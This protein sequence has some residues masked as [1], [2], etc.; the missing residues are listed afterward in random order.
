M[1]RIAI[2][3]GLLLLAACGAPGPDDAPA[4][5][6]SAALQPPAASA[7]PAG[8][9]ADSAVAAETANE[10]APA[11]A[12]A[13]ARDTGSTAWTSLELPSEPWM[14]RAA[15]PAALLTRVRDV[16][17][18]QLEEPD[19]EVLLT[20]M[21]AQQADSALAVLVHPDLADDSVRDI[22]FRLHMRRQGAEWAIVG[23]DRRERCRRGVTPDNLCA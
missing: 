3:P 21:E 8:T 10:G 15:T 14:Q 4:A 2:V 16:V 20:R 5:D 12:Q 18:A 6:T 17:A 23:V 22:E 9:P 7:P 13:A 11:A 19:A 1:M